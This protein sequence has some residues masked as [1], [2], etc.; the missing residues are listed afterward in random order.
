MMTDPL[1]PA[2]ERT[3]PELGIPLTKAPAASEPFRR[4]LMTDNLGFRHAS[5]TAGDFH[6][7]RADN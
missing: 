2:D 6:T 1:L 4:A 7:I 5:S 3:G